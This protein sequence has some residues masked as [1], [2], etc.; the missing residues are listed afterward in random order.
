MASD[1]QS[2]F[3]STNPARDT[4]EPHFHAAYILENIADAFVALD[5]NWH[6]LYAN[7][8][9]CRINQKPLA[10]FVGKV[11]WEEWPGAVGTE[12]ERQFH[13]TMRERV[14]TH[15]EHRYLLE[16][17]DIWL[18]IEAYPSE[19]GINLFYRDITSRKRAEEELK[20]SEQ[21]YRSLVEATAEIVWTNSPEGKMQGPQP[22]WGGFT[23][24]T[25]AEYQGYGWAQAIHPDDAQAT[26]EAWS[27]AVAAR[28]TFLF[29]HRVRRHDGV[30]R[31][32]AIRAAAV[33]DD[34]GAIREWV[35]VHTDITERKEAERA[36][37]ESETRKRAILEAALDC[38]V[39]MDEDQRIIEWNPA[40]ERTFGYSQAQALGQP[41]ASLLVP[42]S[43]RI[44]HAQG[45][46]HY[47]ATGEGPILNQR[48][49][50]PGLHANGTQ[51]PVELTVVPIILEGRFLFTAYVRDLTERRRAEEELSLAVVRQRTFLRDVLA[52]VTE[53]HL[54]LCHT[55]DELPGL[56]ST[57]GEPIALSPEGGLGQLRQRT[58][59]AAERLPLSSERAHEL[60]T[61]VSEAGMNAVVHAGGGT[62]QV[63]VSDRRDMMQV[64]IVDA[65][66]GITL[67]N[68]PHATLKR[69]YTTSGTLGHGM[70][71]MLQTADRVF[72]LTGSA[73]TTVL[74]EQDRVAA[75]FW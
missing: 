16:P 10:E 62:G 44:A 48:I 61:A 36:V 37:R 22:G 4:T 33:L 11:H 15:F 31:A 46:A 39:T 71:M 21:R 72:L 54:I 9:A 24:Q 32:F 67:E 60:V 51:F 57:F 8:E 43:L 70:K 29:E 41:M 56:H 20:R 23:G 69:G 34:G 47:L 17:Y 27:Q 38:I 1:S 3:L 53:G 35:G 13:R 2:D 65:G 14:P 28:Q 75:P 68:L 19:D 45:L 63:C 40:A 66:A 42:P 55:P 25:E 74:L 49:E 73:G 5:K 52:G 58:R 12:L 7:R 50:V 26:V 59:E 30:Y 6:I 18:E 64:K